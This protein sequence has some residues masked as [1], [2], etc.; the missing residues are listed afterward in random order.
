MGRVRQAHLSLDNGLDWVFYL[1]TIILIP[2]ASG[3]DIFRGIRD[4]SLSFPSVVIFGIGLLISMV[5]SYSILNRFRLTRISGT[6]WQDNYQQVELIMR[7][8]NGKIVFSN[9]VMMVISL[10]WKWNSTHWGKQLIIIFDKEDILVN[11]I[12]F[13]AFG[14]VS[15]FHWFGNRKIESNLSKA[16]VTK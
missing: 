3:M 8:M 16:F 4:S 1:F 5:L 6:S 9:E 14:I 13:L 15:P 2:L 11:C 10:P 12:S 7:Q